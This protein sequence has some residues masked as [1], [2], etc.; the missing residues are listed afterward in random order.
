MHTASDFFF[1]NKEG[2][3]VVQDHKK[4][5]KPKSKIKRHFKTKS[6][7]PSLCFLAS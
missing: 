7:I 2:F 3:Q 5:V 4:S 1:E 6:I